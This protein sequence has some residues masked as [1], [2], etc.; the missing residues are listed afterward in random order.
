MEE[1]ESIE[2]QTLESRLQ[3]IQEKWTSRVTALNEKMKSLYDID[4]LLN[5]VYADRQDLVD[6]YTNIMFTLAK[7]TKQYNVKVAECY[8]RL[9]VGENGI[10]YTN[11][12]AINN[13]IEAQLSEV[14]HPI[15]LLSSHIEYLRETMKTIDSLIFGISSKIKVYELVNGKS[16]K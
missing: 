9:K 15:Q 11:E 16:T 2:Q 14:K 3:M 13:Q 5:V 1:Q 6:Y 4:S 7:L 10:R 8:N 12:S